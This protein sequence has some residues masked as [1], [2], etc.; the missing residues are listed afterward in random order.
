MEGMTRPTDW[1][2]EVTRE[3]MTRI[4][5]HADKV[6]LA[7][8]DECTFRALFMAAAH[9]LLD[10]PRFQTEWRRFDL[11]VQMGA[12]ATVV[13]FKYYLV[14]RTF[15]LRGEPLGYKGGAGPKNEA[16]FR[17]CVHKL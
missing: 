8:T 10:A 16:E 11:L 9:D 17:D 6:G 15:G 14:R 1:V 4:L 12:D 13:E 7:N 2:L 5:A 3:A